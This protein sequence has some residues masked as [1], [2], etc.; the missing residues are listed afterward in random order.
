MQMNPHEVLGMDDLGWT[1]HFKN[2]VTIGE[3]THRTGIC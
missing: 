1:R 3:D 2:E